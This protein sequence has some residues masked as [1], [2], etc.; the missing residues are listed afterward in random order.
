MKGAYTLIIEVEQPVSIQLPSLGNI[1]FEL[2]QWVYVGSAMG[3]GSTSLEKR[4]SRHFRD[5]K[6]IY[7]HIDHLLDADVKL[8]EAIWSTSTKPVECDLA[9]A[10]A[11]HGDFNHGPK[12]FGSSDCRRGC[13]AHTFFYH[14]EDQLQSNLIQVFN[15]LGLE[16]H[17]TKTGQLRH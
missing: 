4:L 10:L 3:N 13:A 5:E 12:K 14:G 11:K 7:W 15:G 2:G 16:P 1:V 6:T 9:Q 8:V 17:V